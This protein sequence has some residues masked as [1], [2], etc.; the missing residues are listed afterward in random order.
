[1]WV[2][3]HIRKWRWCQYCRRTIFK[4]VCYKLD[5]NRHYFICK[6]CYHD[7]VQSSEVEDISQR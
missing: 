5:S 2:K 3:T 6:E 1:M 7:K 4:E